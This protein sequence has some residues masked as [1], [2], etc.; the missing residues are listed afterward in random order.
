MGKRLFV[1]SVFLVGVLLILVIGA[2]A[3]SK[4]I[5]TKGYGTIYGNNK[6]A[7]RDKAIED[8]QRKAVEQAMGTMI[9][10]ESVTK[11]FQLISDRILSLSSGYIER[12]R[13]ISEREINGEVEVEI[14]AIVGMS[15]LNDSLQAIKNLI[16]RMDR[17]RIMV[18]IAEQSIREERQ[19]F[20]EK[21]RGYAVLSSTSLGV[22]ENVLIE[23]FRAK[24]FDFV[25]RQALAGQIEIADPLTLVNDRE[26]VKQ[27]ANL[28][29]AQV[30]IFGQAQARNTGEVQGIYSGQAN[31]SLRALKT[32]TG[33]IIAATNAHAAVPFVDPSTANIRALSEAARKISQKLMDQILSKWQS[34]SSGSRSICLVIKGVRYADV[35]KLRTWLTK[36]VR[37]VK[38]VH[39]RYV[40]DGIAELDLDIQGSAQNLADE[41]SEKN[42]QSK[43]IEV[44]DLSPNKVSIELR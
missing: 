23:F 42:F 10:S 44:L 8:A 13:V 22:T 9:S 15:K 5:R 39:Q 20:A 25:D 16:R 21:N 37:G 7:A 26:R 27:I 17:P 41:L 29:D 1:H 2:F 24:G 19:E 40:K 32:D 33:E 30:V 31:I 11:N 36:Y 35:K 14:A 18:L 38:S 12:Y 28:T 43:T 6:A 3:Q 34:E 4:E